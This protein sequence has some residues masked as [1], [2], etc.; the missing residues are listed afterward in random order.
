MSE[1]AGI[2]TQ[3]VGLHNACS[4]FSLTPSLW[5]FQKES[6]SPLA[7]GHVWFLAFWAQG[8][9][10]FLLFNMQTFLIALVFS[11]MPHFCPLCCTFVPKAMTGVQTSVFECGRGAGGHLSGLGEGSWGVHSLYMYALYQSSCFHVH[12]P[13]SFCVLCASSPQPL[14]V[15]GVKPPCFLFGSQTWSAFRQFSLSFPPSKICWNFKIS[16]SVILPFYVVI[17]LNPFTVSWLG[18]WKGT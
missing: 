12:V 17:F 1:G 9:S 3:A 4:F 8:T 13:P 15:V 11:T 14:W 10:R 7:W 18:L 2:G 6:H 16:L 5:F